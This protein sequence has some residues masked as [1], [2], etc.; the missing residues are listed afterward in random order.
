MRKTTRQPTGDAMAID[1]PL[2]P[3]CGKRV[4]VDWEV[5]Q[6]DCVMTTREQVRHTPG[7]WTVR[8]F[9][10]PQWDDDPLGVYKIEEVTRKLELADQ[11]AT[12]DIDNEYGYND[13][14]DAIHMEQHANARLI[15]AAPEMGAKLLELWNAG[16]LADNETH[17]LLTKAGLI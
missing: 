8:P 5:H 17:A 7:P 1:F 11:L 6:E 10:V 16:I 13:Q 14:M 12:N 4:M 3:D 9:N 2:C 15:A